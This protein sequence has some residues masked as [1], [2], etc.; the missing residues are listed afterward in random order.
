MKE[1]KDRVDDAVH[2]TR[3]ALEEGVLLVGGLALHLAKES[4]EVC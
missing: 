4:F 2:A 3:A 1:K